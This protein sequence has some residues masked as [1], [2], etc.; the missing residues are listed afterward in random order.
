M[1]P[2]PV[3]GV[4]IPTLCRDKKVEESIFLL[5]FLLTTHILF[6]DVS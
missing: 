5:Q 2:L 6:L 3:P 1:S 4:V